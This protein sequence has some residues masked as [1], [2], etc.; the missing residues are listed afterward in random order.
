MGS[1]RRGGESPP[2]TSNKEIDLKNKKD[3]T[4]DEAEKGW[5]A[6]QD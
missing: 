3:K 5:N 6:G 1:R 2:K 4:S